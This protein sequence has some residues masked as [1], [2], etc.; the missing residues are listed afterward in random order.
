[1]GLIGFEVAKVAEAASAA[2]TASAAT[3]SKASAAAEATSSTAKTTAAAPALRRQ[4]HRPVPGLH[5][6]RP[7][8]PG[9]PPPESD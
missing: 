8:L 2:A 7:D 4:V 5:P 9:P 6:G 3:S 1:M